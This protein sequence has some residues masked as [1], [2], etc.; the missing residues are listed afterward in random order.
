MYCDNANCNVQAHNGTYFNSIEQERCKIVFVRSI[1]FDSV[2]DG[3]IGA[4]AAGVL[5][6]ELSQD[7]DAANGQTHGDRTEAALSGKP[8]QA[9]TKLFPPPPPGMTEI[10]TCAV[11]LDRL[12]ASASGILTTLCNHTFHCD[13]LFRWEG[14]SCPVC[15]YSHGDIVSAC[16]VCFL[17]VQCFV[18]TRVV[19]TLHAAGLPYNGAPL[20]L[21]H[22]RPRG[23]RSLFGRTCEAAFPRDFTHI[24]LG[25]GDPA[26]LGLCWR[27]VWQSSI[28]PPAVS[29]LSTHGLSSFPI[30]TFTG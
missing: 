26:S 10:P 17:S 20:D 16:E 13:C 23:L 19:L 27:W 7:A 6:E 12:D 25:V 4:T 28:R 3:A 30:D 5:V 22:L 14:S 21:P 1:E 8:P 15:R 2:V 29:L 11:C 9:A 18:P 24:L